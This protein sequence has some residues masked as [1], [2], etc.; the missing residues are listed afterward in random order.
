MSELE[1][2]LRERLIDLHGEIG[3]LR[4]ILR[5][6]RAALVRI[7]QICGVEDRLTLAEKRERYDQAQDA[8]A[9][10]KDE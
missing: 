3:K 8:L 9:L 4:A 10:W 6:T 7:V 2:Q 1:D 5:Q